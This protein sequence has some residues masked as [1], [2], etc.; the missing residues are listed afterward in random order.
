MSKKSKTHFFLCILL[1][2][3]ASVIQTGYGQTDA[4]GEIKIRC[5]QMKEIAHFLQG[6]STG[7]VTFDSAKNQ[8]MT[9][10]TT[11]IYKQNVNCVLMRETL[12]MDGRVVDDVYAVNS[13]YGF[14]L[15]RKEGMEWTVK[16]LHLT[17]PGK[18]TYNNRK[19]REHVIV[20]LTLSYSQ[21]LVDGSHLLSKPKADK[22]GDLVVF[23]YNQPTT[24][25]SLVVGKGTMTFDRKLHMAL[26]AVNAI[27]RFGPDP[28]ETSTKVVYEYSG[29]LKGDLAKLIKRTVQRSTPNVKMP[30]GVTLSYSVDEYDLKYDENVP[31]SEF[32]LTAFGIPEP[33]GIIWDQPRR[34]I[35]IWWGLPGIILVVLAYLWYRWRSN[36]GPV[37]RAHL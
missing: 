5:E 23:E 31:D 13:K 24:K 4:L 37:A 11:H 25:Q 22:S 14:I 30:S 3:F 33:K 6:K 26:V 32:T 35:W 15:S 19:L 21:R 7:T 29:T 10:V 18:V 8:K 28:K 34:L 1:A 16:E 36:A 12:Q 9:Q 20:P 2:V 17:D 27:S